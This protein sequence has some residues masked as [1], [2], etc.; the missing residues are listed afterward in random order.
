[1]LF[2]E[3]KKKEVINLKNCQKLGRVTDFE[4]DE[5]TGQIFKLVVSGNNKL[6][7]F[8]SCEQDYIICYKDIKQI[9]PDIIIV[10]ICIK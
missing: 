4:F 1:M 5:C 10:D 9:G 6:A 7:G 3:F 2:S 8:F